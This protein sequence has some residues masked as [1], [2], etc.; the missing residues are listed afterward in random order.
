MSS[1]LVSNW[2]GAEFNNLHPLIRQL[3][4][5]GGTL[6]GNIELT[7]GRGPAGLIGRRL[8][9]KLG[10]P[11]Q[12]GNYPFTVDISHTDTELIWRREFPHSTMVSSFTPVGH[13]PDGYWKGRT[14]NIE[15]HLGVSTENSGWH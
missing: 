11:P 14:G 8:G 1:D 9:R 10:L 13:Y 4:T 12:P 15:M 3:H 2:F 6:S 7:F 5:S